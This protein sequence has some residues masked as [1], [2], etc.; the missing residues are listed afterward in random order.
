[1]HL[2]RKLYFF[3]S[4]T[5]GLLNFLPCPLV[6]LES[7]TYRSSLSTFSR[8]PEYRY[9]A[10]RSLSF[11]LSKVGSYSFESLSSYVKYLR[12]GMI[13][14]AVLC[15]LSIFL[16]SFFLCSDHTIDAYSNFGLIISSSRYIN[17]T[18]IFLSS[19]YASCYLS[20]V[21]LWRQIALNSH[22]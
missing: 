19:L 14:V 2:Y 9:P 10:I 7:Q 21:F 1:M 6:F 4:P 15:I 3:V 17:A 16:I 5:H 13:L 20:Y 18:L 12:F 8:S 11:L 22:T